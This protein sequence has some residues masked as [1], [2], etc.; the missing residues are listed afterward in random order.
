[1]YKD[2]PIGYFQIWEENDLFYLSDLN[3]WGSVTVIL[4]YN[5]IIDS[6]FCHVFSFIKLVNGYASNCGISNVLSSK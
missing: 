4:D 3:G 5:A 6:G 1:M 2:T